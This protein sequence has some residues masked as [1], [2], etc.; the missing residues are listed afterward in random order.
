MDQVVFEKEL[1]MCKKLHHERKGCHWGKCTNCGVIPLL[2]KVHKGV[3][4]EDAEE[5]RKMFLASQFKFYGL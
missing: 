4:L 5:I 1:L 3:I 2:H